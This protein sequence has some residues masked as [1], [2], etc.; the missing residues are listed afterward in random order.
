VIDSFENTAQRKCRWRDDAKG[1]QFFFEWSSAYM[2]WNNKADMATLKDQ[3]GEPVDICIYKK[4]SHQG[5]DE[6]AGSA[7]I[8]LE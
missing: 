5:T 3:R 6:R 2:I 8:A 1:D 7:Y 4:S